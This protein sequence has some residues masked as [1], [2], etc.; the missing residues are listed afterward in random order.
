MAGTSPALT[1]IAA[2][3]SPAK[4]GHAPFISDFQKLT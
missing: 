4:A 2:Q 3:I 1:I